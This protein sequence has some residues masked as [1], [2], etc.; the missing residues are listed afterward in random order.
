MIEYR[1][2]GI[3][4]EMVGQPDGVR[5][6]M[7]EAGALMFFQLRRP[8]AAERANVEAGMP[9]RM[10]LFSRNDVM[11]ILVKAGSF[12]WWDAPFFPIPGSVPAVEGE[13][14]RTRRKAWP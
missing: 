2:G 10:G 9:M 7:D 4:P 8:E 14:R 6:T 12:S 1:Q 13:L 11:I 3:I 5:F